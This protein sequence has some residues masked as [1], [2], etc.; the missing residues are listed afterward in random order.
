SKAEEV[1]EVARKAAQEALTKA[2]EALVR[3]VIKRLTRGEWIFLLIVINLA[4][5]FAAV[6]LAVAIGQAI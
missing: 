4:V 2:E 3:A 6:L 5:V 1:A